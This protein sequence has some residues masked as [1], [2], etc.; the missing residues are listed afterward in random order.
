M[1]NTRNPWLN[2]ENIKKPERVEKINKY[3]RN[4]TKMNQESASSAAPNESIDPS[5]SCSYL[6][7]NIDLPI[8]SPSPNQCESTCS[9]ATLSSSHSSATSAE[10]S[11]DETNVLKFNE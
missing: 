11:D 3:R 10:E 1:G 2:D 5:T 6:Q 7:T 8:L 9:T 4:K